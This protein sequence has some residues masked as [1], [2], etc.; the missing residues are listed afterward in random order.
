LQCYAQEGTGGAQSHLRH[1]LG[2][3]FQAG[4]RPGTALDLIEDDQIQ[5][6][7]DGPIEV[8]LQFVGE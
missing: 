5:A 6:A 3:I 1:L 4:Q 8:K 2:E 7:V